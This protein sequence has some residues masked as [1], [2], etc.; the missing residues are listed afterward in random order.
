MGPTSSY[1]FFLDWYRYA[2]QANADALNRQREQNVAPGDIVESAYAGLIAAVRG[3][4]DECLAC[5]GW[6][7]RTYSPPPHGPRRWRRG[8]HQPESEKALVS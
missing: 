1:K 4:V 6:R 8:R 5:S 3:A 2:A 7:N